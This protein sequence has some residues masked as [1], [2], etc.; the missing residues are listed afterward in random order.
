[1]FQRYNPEIQNLEVYIW[2]Y[3]FFLHCL[4]RNICSEVAWTANPT[5]NHKPKIYGSSIWCPRSIILVHTSDKPKDFDDVN[6]FWSLFAPEYY[7]TNL[8]KF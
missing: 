4:I 3:V 8:I 7:E 5:E 6:V 1:M 2:L